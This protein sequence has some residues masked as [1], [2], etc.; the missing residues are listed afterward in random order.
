MNRGQYLDLIKESINKHGFHITTVHSELVPRYSYTIGLS[1]SLGFEL[2]FAGGIYFMYEEVLKIINH[3]NKTLQLKKEKVKEF[4]VKKIGKFSIS[5]VDQSW[6]KL[7]MLGT[8]DYFQLDEIKA[9]Q[10]KPITPK[11]TL[12]LDIPDMKIKWEGNLNPI[13]QWLK[14]EWKYPI[15]QNSKVVTNLDVLRGNKVTEIMRWKQNEWEG[16]AG[17]GPDVKKED[18]RIVPVGTILALDSSLI[19]ITELEIGKGLWRENESK[20][21]NSWG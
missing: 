8:Y 11:L 16:F 18:I 5:D 20:T 13:W 2:I 9:Y 12:T 17:A 4:E 1:V 19:S 14:N 7:T 21:W 10:I 3:A 15:P 6:S